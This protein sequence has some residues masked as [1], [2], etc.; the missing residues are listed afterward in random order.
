MASCTLVRMSYA[1]REHEFRWLTRW[2]FL[3]TFSIQKLYKWLLHSLR[4][5]IFISANT[6]TF[7]FRYSY[8]WKTLLDAGIVCAG[9]SDS[10][11]DPPLSLR[12]I[13]DAIYRPAGERLG[14]Y[15]TF[16]PRLALLI[17]AL[18]SV[19]MKNWYTFFH[20]C[21]HCVTSCPLHNISTFN[22]DMKSCQK[23]VSFL[24][25]PH[26]TKHSDFVQ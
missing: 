13:Y 1:C 6:Q 23:F 11:V 18:A 4:T 25:V 19:Y 3:R 21:C 15:Y 8:A 20:R 12:G 16:W 5:S 14:E 9:G 7:A 17:L 24:T 26:K 2:T 10:P 22:E